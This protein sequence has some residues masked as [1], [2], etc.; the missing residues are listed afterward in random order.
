LSKKCSIISS[1]GW[2]CLLL[3]GSGLNKQRNRRFIVKTKIVKDLMVS[4]SDYA[5]VSEDATLYDAIIALEEAQNKFDKS[6]YR[7]RAILIYDKNRHITGKVSQNDILR[8]L[9]PK[10]DEIG[11]RRGI[12]HYGFSKKLLKTLREQ[13]SLFDKPMEEIC[14]KT[15]VLK[16]KNIMYTPT[17]G[18][19]VNANDSL[20]IA[21]HRLVMGHHQ[22]LLVTKDG[23]IKNIVGIL[24]KTDVFMEVC[25]AI[26]ACNL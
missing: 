5:T 22:A 10:Y 13:F 14:K 8:A 24:R 18:E 20:D 3:A 2:I 25:E 19:Y 15:A 26:K 16:V 9:E 12:A 4:L 6:R 1:L 23:D 21:I 11:N 7:H 17:E